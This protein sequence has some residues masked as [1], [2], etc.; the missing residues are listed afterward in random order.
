MAKLIIN[1]SRVSPAEWDEFVKTIREANPAVADEISKDRD[2]TAYD[3]QILLNDPNTSISYPS[4]F[5]NIAGLLQKHHFPE[6]IRPPA[7]ALMGRFIGIKDPQLSRAANE[8]FHE[9]TDNVSRTIKSLDRMIQ[10]V[11]NYYQCTD[12]KEKLNGLREIIAGLRQQRD[13]L[14]KFRS[15]CWASPDKFYDINETSVTVRDDVAYFLA[16]AKSVDENL[17]TDEDAAL[18]IVWEDTIKFDWHAGA[19]EHTA[20]I[21]DKILSFIPKKPSFDIQ[22]AEIDSNGKIVTSVTTGL[23]V[24]DSDWTPA[25]EVGC[26]PD[27][28]RKAE[29]PAP[30]VAAVT[31][32]SPQAAPTPAPAP[33]RVPVLPR[34]HQFR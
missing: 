20:Q 12:D 19:V 11:E 32:P 21:I 8:F 16:Y 17:K 15:F 26:N 31:P 34:L 29:V 3:M 24:R 13:S 4:A 30:R 25:R 27:P 9:T 2:I 22:V 28:V 18:A 33:P 1:E 6:S 14:E 7:T 23:C 10:W 5:S